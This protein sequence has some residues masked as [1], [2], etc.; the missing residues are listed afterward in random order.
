MIGD[1]MYNKYKSGELEAIELL[2]KYGLKFDLEYTDKGKQN[3]PDLLLCDGN[4]IEVTHTDHYI[5]NDGFYRTPSNNK[6][7]KENKELFKG[8][9][10][11]NY[12][13]NTLESLKRQ[14]INSKA[15]NLVDIPKEFFDR[16]DKFDNFKYYEKIINNINS[17]PEEIKNNNYFEIDELEFL[18]ARYYTF[19]FDGG[20]S[21]EYSERTILSKLREKQKK[22]E[23]YKVESNIDCF[24][25]LFDSEFRI[26]ESYYETRRFN[27]SYDCFIKN[28]SN[29]GFDNIYFGKY[30]F[31][32]Q[33][34][35]MNSLF[36]FKLI[37]RELT[38]I[39]LKKS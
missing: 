11:H 21:E 15:Y 3:M 39:I 20:H 32:E 28:L 19:V 7:F 12:N 29:L 37:N 23:N 9:E 1:C 22:K 6:Y 14:I 31:Y 30:D 13:R 27:A 24:I 5:H 25:W 38:L 17:L 34:Y 26:V 2:Q 35:D 4:Y 8:I 10:V 16:N 33:N 18:L 36:K